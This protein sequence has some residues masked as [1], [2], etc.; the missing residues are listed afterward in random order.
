MKPV[1]KNFGALPL[2]HLIISKEICHHW[3]AFSLLAMSRLGQVPYCGD[4]GLPSDR[5][6]DAILIRGSAAH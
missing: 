2:L 1:R 6:S 4:M 5:F 3:D